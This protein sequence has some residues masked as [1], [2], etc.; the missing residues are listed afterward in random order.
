M[1]PVADG[2]FA[3][4]KASSDDRGTFQALAA[5]IDE[6]VEDGLLLHLA[7]AYRRSDIFA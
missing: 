3:M 5:E 6:D 7:I 4:L 2:C 1:G